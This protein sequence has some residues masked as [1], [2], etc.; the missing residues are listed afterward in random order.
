MG[1]NIE[2]DALRNELRECCG[3]ISGV[4][5]EIVRCVEE[6]R[7]EAGRMDEELAFL[8]HLKSRRENILHQIGE[9]TARWGGPG[10]VD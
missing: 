2:V 6:N 4:C 10:N 8:Y 9:I 3:I 7:L 5:A 1:V